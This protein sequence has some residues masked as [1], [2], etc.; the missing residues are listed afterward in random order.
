MFERDTNNS[1]VGGVASGL[2][3]KYNVSVSLLR[4]LFL[5]G[6]LVLGIGLAVYA[7]FW[8]NNPETN[9]TIRMNFSS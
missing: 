2:S 4:I 7:W 8:M 5:L 3:D 1:W 6:F 9:N